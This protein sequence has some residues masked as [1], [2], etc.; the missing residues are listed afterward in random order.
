MGNSGLMQA[1]KS[2]H[3]EP[4]GNDRLLE[5]TLFVVIAGLIAVL[6]L[7]SA[8]LLIAPRLRALLVVWLMPIATRLP[9]IHHRARNLDPAHI[10][11]LARRILVVELAPTAFVFIAETF[12]C[13]W[14]RCSLRRLLCSQQSSIS[15][16]VALFGLKCFGLAAVAAV[17]LTLGI[18]HFLNKLGEAIDVYL[19]GQNRLRV[20]TGSAIQ[21]VAVFYLG[22]TF[23]A[24]WA[25]RLKHFGPFWYLHRVHHSAK[26]LTI[27]TNAR[28]HPA[29]QPFSQ[30]VSLIGVVFIGC[31]PQFVIP[32]LLYAKAHDL[33]LHC[34]A[35]WDWGWLGRWVIASPLR[36]RLHHSI[37]PQHT[38]RNFA[39][40][41]LWDHLFGT[42]SGDVIDD[43]IGISD[44]DYQDVP[45]WAP[46]LPRQL[47]DDMYAFVR[48]IPGTI[49][50]GASGPEHN[51]RHA[52]L[53]HLG[54]TF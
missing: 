16:D 37:L 22:Y 31:P 43:A 30:F 36:H 1:V 45:Y 6:L 27:I 29:E 19:K 8:A 53:S 23:F 20:Q 25:H 38:N 26:E 54:A 49:S 7:S 48:A 52:A 24:Y 35:R 41:P 42:Y 15:V 50:R 2:R 12:G 14:Q 40:C 21:D 28:I 33:I 44:A 51:S 17:V 47:I 11:M 46:R 32:M 9:V 18:S 34:N 4:V 10:E 13:G 39:I 5:T 3:D